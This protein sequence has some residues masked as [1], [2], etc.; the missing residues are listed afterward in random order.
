MIIFEILLYICTHDTRW[1]H[2]RR[3]IV[4]TGVVVDIFI[5]IIVIVIIIRIGGGGDNNSI[6]IIILII[7]SNNNKEAV[8]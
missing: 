5:N 7:I 6:I 2:G 8:S 4:F 1:R 3:M